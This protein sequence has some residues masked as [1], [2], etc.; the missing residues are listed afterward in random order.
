VEMKMATHH[1]NIL[2]LET[3]RHTKADANEVWEACLYLNM[4]P[5]RLLLEYFKRDKYRAS[6]PL[7]KHLLL[8]LLALLA[9]NK[10]A[11]DIHQSLRLASAGNDKLSSQTMQDIINHSK[12]IE[13]RG[14]NHSAAVSKDFFTSN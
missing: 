4:K 3:A 11:E 6:S 14:I 8:G 7:G 5:V 12:V 9:D 1:K 2:S 13:N 10:I